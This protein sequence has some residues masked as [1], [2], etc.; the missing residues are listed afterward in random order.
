[1]QEHDKKMRSSL[2]QERKNHQEVIK[3]QIQE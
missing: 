3:E 1:M 2:V